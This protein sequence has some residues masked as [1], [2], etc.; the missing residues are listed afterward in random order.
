MQVIPTNGSSPSFGFFS[1]A[2]EKSASSFMDA[3]S[4]ALDAVDGGSYSSVSSALSDEKS[5]WLVESPYTRHTSDG[6]TYTLSEVCFTKSELAELREQLIKEGAP[7]E[8]LKQFDILAGQPDGATLAQVMASLMGSKEKR[9]SEEDAQAITSLLGQIDPS[10]QLAADALD[11][12][13]QGQGAQALNR[14]QSALENM[15]ADMEID[16]DPDSLLALGRGLG[17]NEGSLRNLAGALNGRSVSVNAASFDQLMQPAKDQFLTEAANADKLNAAL[18]KTLRPIIAK[19]RS[20]MEK[21]EAAAAL[22]N[23]R[24]EQSKILIDETVQKNSR[25]M[26][27]E[28]VTGEA[29]ERRHAGESGE[30]ADARLEGALSQSAGAQFAQSAGNTQSASNSQSAG[31]AQSARNEHA[32]RPAQSAQAPSYAADERPAER[33]FSQGGQNKPS[34]EGWSGLLERTSVKPAQAAKTADRTDSIVYSMLQNNFIEPASFAESAPAGQPAPL[35]AQLASQ[36]EQGMLTAMRDGA[37]RLDLQLHPAELGSM[38]ITLIARNGEIT[39]QIRSE[40]SETAEMVT[41]QLDA[42]KANLE[43][44]GLK[45]DKIEVQLENKG[46]N[47]Q[48]SFDNLDQH[49]ARQ[50]EG[51]FRQELQRLRNLANVRRLSGGE[52]NLAQNMQQIRQTAIY[53]AQGLHVVA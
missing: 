7:M 50:E 33:D 23:R 1:G 53:S 17:L 34:D 32:A 15:G 37:T 5:Q 36:V 19:A 44:Q 18:D 28:T 35:S 14:I 38:A 40:K 46:E 21:E 12:M 49:N 24:V 10:G 2:G 4:D 47:A 20:R 13:R 16:V 45:V 25:E 52:N 42:I 43:Q 29:A 51:A 9:F 27:D 41:R 30:L 6:V 8:S 48:N 11:L 26:M 22:S 39:A 31:N 3:M